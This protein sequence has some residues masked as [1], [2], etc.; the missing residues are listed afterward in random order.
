MISEMEKGVSNAAVFCLFAS[1]ASLKS[2]WVGFEIDEAKIRSITDEN[3]RI[4]VYIIDSE[5]SAADLPSWMRRLW[6]GN[7]SLSAKDIARHIL[8]S[9]QDSQ[10]NNILFNAPVLGRGALGDKTATDFF[11]IATK[12]GKSPSVL[13]VS[14]ISGI[15]RRTFSKEI[16]QK[17]FPHLPSLRYGPTIKI[18]T[19][20]G[21]EDLWRLIRENIEDSEA[22]SN[23]K[24]ELDA[25]N[26]LPE[27]EKYR[28]ISNSFMY[29]SLNGQASI[30]YSGNSF[31]NDDGSLKGWSRGLLQKLADSD[32]IIFFVSNRRINYSDARE[33]SHILQIHVPPLSNELVS[34]IISSL[35]AARGEKPLELP[36]QFI[37][38]IGGHPGLA[39]MIADLLSEQGI[40]L[41]SKDPQIFYNIQD[42]ILSESL[43][44]DRLPTVCKYILCILSW[45]PSLYSDLLFDIITEYSDASD[46]DVVESVQFLM[47]SSLLAVY[48]PNFEIT[49]S[50]RYAFRRRHGYGD[51]ALLSLF[52]AKMKEIWADAEKEDIEIT[53]SMIDTIAYMYALEGKG[54][55][56]ELASTITASTLLQ[57]IQD[58]YNRGRE[59]FGLFRTVCEWGKILGVI[60]SDDATREEILSYVV[61][62]HIRLKDKSASETLLKEI[63]AKGYRSRHF[64]WG[65]YYRTFRKYDEA[66]KNYR[67]ALHARKYLKSCIHELAIC[68]S[69]TGDFDS[70]DR[71]LKEYDSMA[72]DSAYLLDFKVKHAIARRDFPEAE[73]ALRRLR[74]MAD[75]QGRSVMREAQILM[76]RDL[77]YD[78]AV[79]LLDRLIEAQSG[80]TAH[81]RTVRAV[82]ASYN[83]EY[84]K[85]REDIEYVR[86]HM[87]NGEEIAQRLEVHFSI[88]KGDFDKAFE[89]LDGIP[90]PT[91]MDDLLRARVMEQKANH[92]RTPLAERASLF[93][94]AAELR[95]LHKNMNDLDF[96]DGT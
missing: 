70:I 39:R 73:T 58:T 80:G 2:K 82:A 68:Y 10:K 22:L 12:N 85:A 47:M 15:G 35:M 43:N 90:D 83:R 60:K 75:D 67:E 19:N 25:F 23:Y 56:K 26:E 31:F 33:F 88:A 92:I 3:F 38:A 9:I 52:S 93:E 48:G 42:E 36:A 41:L 14:G 28:E 5:I 53:A 13:F 95:K 20:G 87:A 37:N 50:I 40:T 89:V 78:K 8:V 86:S 74:F 64:L 94:A 69:V 44:Y 66:I 76:L 91:A 11:Q 27:D 21:I 65:F 57:A 4:L 17:C 45:V 81:P 1:K 29:F 84:P 51:E 59:N 77:R 79:G 63:D 55:P 61:R 71:L 54:M 30:V 49:S 7:T 16:M 18:P 96:F 6:S 72:Q 24:S 46:S 62:A 34:T 32:S